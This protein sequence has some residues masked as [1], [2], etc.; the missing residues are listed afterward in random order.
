MFLSGV[1]LCFHVLYVM[2]LSHFLPCIIVLHATN[3]NVTWL[4]SHFTCAPKCKSSVCDLVRVSSLILVLTG[5]DKKE[6]T[7]SNKQSDLHFGFYDFIHKN[8]T[9]GDEGITVDFR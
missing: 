1:K 8:K 6:E 7:D 4:P 5:I 3:Q 9:I 2:C